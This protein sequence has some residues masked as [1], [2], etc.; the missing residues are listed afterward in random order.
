MNMPW[1]APFSDEE[2]GPMSLR[3]VL[4][5]IQLGEEPRCLIDSLHP[6]S[7]K[8]VRSLCTAE[9]TGSELS[10]RPKEAEHS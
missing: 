2:T 1:L 5:V 6:Q 7:V 10:D 9:K 3:S 4:K 8:L